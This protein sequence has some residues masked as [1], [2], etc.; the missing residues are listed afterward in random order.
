[1]RTPKLIIN[2]FISD[3]DINKYGYNNY[4]DFLNDRDAFE[5]WWMTSGLDSISPEDRDSLLTTVNEFQIK[6]KGM[7]TIEAMSEVYMDNMRQS[8]DDDAFSLFNMIN[9]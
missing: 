4:S 9:E 3:E 2:Q 5:D 1:M 6:N 8:I 7:Q